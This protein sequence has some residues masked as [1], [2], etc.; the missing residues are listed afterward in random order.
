MQKLHI[1]TIKNK[2]G[3]LSDMFTDLRVLNGTAKNI[4]NLSIGCE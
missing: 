4:I 2:I 1:T 3:V